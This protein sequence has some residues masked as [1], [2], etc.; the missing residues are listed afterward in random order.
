MT[1]VANLRKLTPRNAEKEY[2]QEMVLYSLYSIAGR[3]LMFKGGTCLYK[4][5]KLN[6]FSEDLDF[7][8]TKQIDAGNLIRKALYGIKLLGINASIKYTEQYH[9]TAN[10]G[11]NFQGL[12]Y[13]RRKDSLCFLLLN[14][15]LREKSCLP[16]KL[17]KISTVYEEFPDFD[18]VVM[19]P[20]EILAEKI[21]AVYS[22]NKP[23]DVYDAWFLLKRLSVDLDVNLVNKK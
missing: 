2:F 1:A 3:E 8:A 12:F 13:D 15:S 17:E 21:A 23:R 9:N 16:P 14:I 10:I 19:D 18:V 4:V 22:R 20:K 6:R 5:Y 7:S 11:I